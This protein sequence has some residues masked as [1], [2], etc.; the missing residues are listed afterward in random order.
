MKV[1]NKSAKEILIEVKRLEDRRDKKSNAGQSC[2]C[3]CETEQS[4][5][6]ELMKAYIENL[7]PGDYSFFMF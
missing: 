7:H 3:S 5:A 2:D 4:E 1:R 6:Y